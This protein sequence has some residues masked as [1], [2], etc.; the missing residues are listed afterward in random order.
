MRRSRS[1]RAKAQLRRM[2]AWMVKKGEVYGRA[3]GVLL[4][5]D[6]ARATPA[7]KAAITM[8]GR[9]WDGNTE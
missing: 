8:A 4:K 1:E 9:G 7:C 2:C 5:L 6:V 3:V